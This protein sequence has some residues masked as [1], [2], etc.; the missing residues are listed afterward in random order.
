MNAFKYGDIVFSQQVFSL[1]FVDVHSAPQPFQR[2]TVFE[3]F[4]VPFE[5]L[6]TKKLMFEWRCIDR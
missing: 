2:K 1:V 3:Y 6:E 5:I 4:D